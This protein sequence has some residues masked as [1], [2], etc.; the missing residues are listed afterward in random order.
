MVWW[1]RVS[2]GM[3]AGPLLVLGRPTWVQPRVPPGAGPAQTQT[4]QLTLGQE[5]TVVQREGAWLL[6]ATG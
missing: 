6:K 2:L 4:L 3:A 5:F 1:G